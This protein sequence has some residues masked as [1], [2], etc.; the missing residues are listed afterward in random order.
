V[1]SIFKVE[2]YVEKETSVEAGNKQKSFH[3]GFFLGLF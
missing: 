1:T 2:E 3:V